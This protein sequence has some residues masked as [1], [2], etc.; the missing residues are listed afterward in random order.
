MCIS[1][2]KIWVVKTK[3]QLNADKTESLLMG[4]APGIDLPCLLCVGQSDIH[5]PVQLVTLV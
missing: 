4:Y 1:G 2:V 3:L 5:F